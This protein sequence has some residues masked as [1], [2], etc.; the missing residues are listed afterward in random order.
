MGSIGGSGGLVEFRWVEMI[1]V[2]TAR[3]EGV[4]RAGQSRILL[5]SP[6]RARTGMNG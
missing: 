3:E 4:V 6:S 2:V 1:G 5:K